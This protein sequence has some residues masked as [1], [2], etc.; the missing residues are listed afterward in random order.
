MTEEIKIVIILKGN[1]GSVG[2]QSPDCDPLFTTFEGDL[3]AA[4]EKVPG[5]VE[6]ANRRWDQSPKYPKCQ[7]TLP[8]ASQA[9]AAPARPAGAPRQNRTQPAMF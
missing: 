8:E 3:R 6:E 7:T 1:R 4:L 5:L 2:I 9:A